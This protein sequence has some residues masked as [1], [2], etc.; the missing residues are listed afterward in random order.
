MCSGAAGFFTLV[1]LTVLGAKEVVPTNCIFLWIFHKSTFSL[2]SSGNLMFI[3]IDEEP[4]VSAENQTDG[5][6]DNK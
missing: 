3:E 4:W 5:N 1:L 2:L 6:C